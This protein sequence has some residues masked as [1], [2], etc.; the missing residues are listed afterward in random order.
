MENRNCIS[1]RNAKNIEGSYCYCKKR[2][3]RK[4]ISS[5]KNCSKY[6]GLGCIICIE[7]ENTTTK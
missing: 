2:M 6:E 1:C 7:K 5:V 3:N 4:Q